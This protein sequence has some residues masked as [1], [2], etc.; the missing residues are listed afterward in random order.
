MI[1][2]MGESKIFFLLRESPSSSTSPCFPRWAV[3]RCLEAVAKEMLPKLGSRE[4]FLW[5]GC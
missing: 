5:K 1:K 3:T 4:L 2:E